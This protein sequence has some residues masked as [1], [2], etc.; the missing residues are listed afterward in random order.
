M[1]DGMQGHTHGA[2]GGA[3]QVPA[4]RLITTLSVAG[5]IAGLLIVLVF[6]WAQPQILANQARATEAAV[7]QV[8]PGG[9]RFETLFIHDGKLTPTLPAGTDSTTLERIYTGYD[10]SGKRVGYALTHGEPGFADV[11]K[12][13]FA[14][15]SKQ[16]RLLGMKVMENRETPGLGDKIV[17]D[18][19]FVNGFRERAIPVRGVKAGEGKGGA[20]EVDMITGAT[21]S[22]RAVIGVINHRLETMR[23]LIEQYE[24]AGAQ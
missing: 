6:Q 19:V 15:D 21:I 7:A 13:M 22:S 12:V 2:A 20:D 23:P 5:A 4:W 3:E 16:N 1:S 14:Y 18:T 9:A 10:A 11:V 24:K 8:L 17:K